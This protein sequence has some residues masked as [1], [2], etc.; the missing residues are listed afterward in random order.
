[1]RVADLGCSRV[2]YV[3]DYNCMYVC[4]FG[5][6]CHMYCESGMT[7]RE[8]TRGSRGYEVYGM[9]LF[10]YVPFFCIGL[11]DCMYV[12]MFGWMWSDCE[13]SN[14]RE[15]LVHGEQKVCV[16]S[17]VLYLCVVMYKCVS[18][19]VYIHKCMLFMRMGIRYTEGLC[20]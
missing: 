19:C 8:V 11:I 5:W 9:F 17:I 20:M 1:M 4:M 7:V 13:G 2:L 16:C 3:F 6:M 18:V 15:Q 14:E 12:W 10:L